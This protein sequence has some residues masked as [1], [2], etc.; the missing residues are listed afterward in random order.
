MNDD[1]KV[2]F[3]QMASAR[4]QIFFKNKQPKKWPIGG[5][6]IENVKQI[7]ANESFIKI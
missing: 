7:S 3:A 5:V 1:K 4:G 6:G 2:R